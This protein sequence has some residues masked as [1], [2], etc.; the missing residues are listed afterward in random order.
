MKSQGKQNARQTVN[1]KVKW[2]EKYHN[3]GHLSKA[4]KAEKGAGAEHKKT[5][6]KGTNVNKAFNK[7]TIFCQGYR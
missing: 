2:K 6:E 1:R 3:T 7:P 4:Q 5:Q